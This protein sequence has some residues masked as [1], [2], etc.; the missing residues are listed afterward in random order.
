MLCAATPHALSQIFLGSI[1]CLSLFIP[2][3]STRSLVVAT[4]PLKQQE[5]KAK[6]FSFSFSCKPR[7]LSVNPIICPL[8]GHT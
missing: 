5:K 4:L 7:G 8:V 1:T 2:F 6:K 3:L